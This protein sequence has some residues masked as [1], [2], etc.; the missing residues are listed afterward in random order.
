MD[1]EFA[2]EDAVQIR[3]VT[4]PRKPKKRAPEQDQLQ[5]LADQIE[6]QKQQRKQQKSIQRQDLSPGLPSI[7]QSLTKSPSNYNLQEAPQPQQMAY[8]NISS[9]GYRPVGPLGLKK[10]EQDLIKRRYKQSYQNVDY[11]REQQS[12]SINQEPQR[13]QNYKYSQQDIAQ[14]YL[15]QKESRLPRISNNRT[16]LAHPVGLTPTSSL[17]KLLPQILMT[18]RNGVHT[19]SL[20]QQTSRRQQQVQQSLDASISGHKL[21]LSLNHLEQNRSV[22]RNHQKVRGV[23]DRVLGPIMEVPSKRL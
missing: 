1:E 23:L 16:D 10:A 2:N 3:E 18:G 14:I 21:V 11:T 22:D 19:K 9:D 13:R 15:K 12:Y 8:I 17:A 5:Q 7:Q 6:M 4:S 20:H